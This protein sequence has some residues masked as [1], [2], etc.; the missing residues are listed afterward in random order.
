MTPIILAYF[1]VALMVGLA[2]I[3]S[4]FG[5]TIAGNAAFGA[6]KKN[7]SA[8]GTYMVL[9]AMPGS[10]G[11]YGFVGYFLVKDLLIPEISIAQAAGIFG[12]GR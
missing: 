7:S 9:A 11:L 3:G 6:M 1:G 5:T 8:F 4:A 2:G 10:Q 12:A